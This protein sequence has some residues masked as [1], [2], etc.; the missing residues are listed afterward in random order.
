[1]ENPDREKISEIAVA[2]LIGICGGLRGEEI[3]L[4][5]ITGMIQFWEETRIHPNIG[6]VVVTMQGKVKVETE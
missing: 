2:V 1:M 4:T 3:F 6:H 5:A